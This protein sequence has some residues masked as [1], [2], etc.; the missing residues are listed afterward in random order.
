ML[1]GGGPPPDS[2]AE[3]SGRKPGVG[4]YVS[5]TVLSGVQEDHEIW[6][7]EVFGPVLCVRPFEDEEEAI[8][9]ANRSEF[10]LAAAVMSS[11]LER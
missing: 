8:S 10:G 3:G 7:S 2:D 5:P 1:C 4:Y 6:D 9:I 11:D